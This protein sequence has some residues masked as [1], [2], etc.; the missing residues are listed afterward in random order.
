MQRSLSRGLIAAALLIAMLAAPVA[1]VHACSCVGMDVATAIEVA[2]L[3]IV[4]TV[5][6][7]VP[8][9][10]DP[11]LGMTLVRYAFEVERA[12]EPTGPIVEVSSH[13]DDMG[14]SCG[15]S[16]GVGE[17]WL[18]AATTDAGTL[19]TTLCSGNLLVEEMGGAQLE[20]VAGLLPFE[21]T[22]D[23]PTP[24]PARVPAPTVG[25]VEF[26]LAAAVVIGLAAS[27]ALALVLTIAMRGRRPS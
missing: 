16:F 19:R 23:A 5:A 18:V 3:A 9:G 21:P 1:S 26:P 14:A 11:N 6:D 22:S 13:D 8:G 20:E 17:Q 27:V 7:A 12:S 10:Q 24:A 4:G 15:F 2:D 25:G